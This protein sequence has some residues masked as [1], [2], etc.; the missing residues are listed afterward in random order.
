VPFRVSVPTPI[1]VGILQATRFLFTQ[2]P[3]RASALSTN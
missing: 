1:G 3:E 2:Q